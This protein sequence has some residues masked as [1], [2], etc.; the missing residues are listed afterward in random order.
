MSYLQYVKK[1][2]NQ[3]LFVK[4][5]SKYQNENKLFIFQLSHVADQNYCI[6]TEQHRIML[7]ASG[8]EAWK[9]ILNF[10]VYQITDGSKTQTYA[11]L[12]KKS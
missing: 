5:H 4:Y 2:V 6:I 1:D 12:K 7:F 11:G 3:V 8:K 10:Q 9:Q